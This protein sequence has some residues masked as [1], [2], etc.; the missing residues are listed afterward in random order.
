MVEYIGKTCPHCKLKIQE[1]ENVVV[2]PDCKTPHHEMCWNKIKGCTTEGCMSEAKHSAANDYEKRRKRNIMISVIVVF[3][4]FFAGL[5]IKSK[6]AE[7]Q[8]K[9]E[10]QREREL[11]Q[12]I[13]ETDEAYYVDV[14]NCFSDMNDNI[15]EL[16]QLSDDYVKLY[17]Y[18]KVDKWHDDSF[19]VAVEDVWDEQ[20]EKVAQ[21]KTEKEAIDK[22][23]EE[24]KSLPD[25]LKDTIC[26]SEGLDV[27]INEYY[28]KYV[29]FYDLVMQNALDCEYDLFVEKC[30]AIIKDIK[31][32]REAVGEFY[33]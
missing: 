5:A 27:K 21:I 7:N 15:V 11:E 33:K 20:A 18:Y 31:N 23:F 2:C 29:E 13:R 12:Q 14:F 19:A 10:E 4:I 8:K 25:I 6:V 26:V 16:A 28:Q 9:R 32:K 3:A 1:G 24:I 30:N 17:K 22:Q